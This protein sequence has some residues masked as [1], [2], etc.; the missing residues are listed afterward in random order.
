MYRKFFSTCLLLVTL[1]GCSL[2]GEPLEKAA[3]GAGKLVT[4]YCENVTDDTVRAQFRE[5]VN[6][7]A[8]PH[9][10]TVSCAQGGESLIVNPIFKSDVCN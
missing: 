5:A 4:F 8:A 6:V 3:E 2:F 10:V 7:E 1:S 9:S